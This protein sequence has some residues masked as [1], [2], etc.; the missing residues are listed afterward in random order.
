MKEDKMKASLF[1]IKCMDDTIHEVTYVDTILYEIRCEVC[2]LSDSRG[3]DIQRE[4]YLNYMERVFSK[5]KRFKN[6]AGDN[7]PH[8]LF[9]LPYRVM[10]KPFRTYKEIRDMLKYKRKI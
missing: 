6:E 2:A 9:S 7:L 3:S 1:C 10:S 4:L 8:F 5:P